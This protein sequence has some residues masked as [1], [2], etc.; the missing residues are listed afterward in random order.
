MAVVEPAPDPLAER[1]RDHLRLSLAGDVG[2]ATLTTGL[3]RLRVRARALPAC[4]LDAVDLS[5]VRWGRRLAVPL[6]VSCMT[7]GVSEAGPVNRALA[8]AAQAHGVAL[9]L[10][11]GRVLLEGDGVRDRDRVASFAVRD[12]APDVLLFANLGAVSLARHGPAACRRL[13]AMCEADALVLH[14]NSVQE[15]I[16]AAA[17]GPAGGDTEFSRVLPRIAEVCAELEVPVLVKEVGFGLAPEDVAALV[18]AGVAG[19]DVA[20]AGGTNWARVEGL[21]DG[22]AGA[23]AA[24]FADWGL[25]TAEAVRGARRVLD[26][27]D[28][29]DVTLI[30]SG[31]LRHGV[32]ALK[33][34]C[35]G[36]DLAGVARGLLAAG[37]EGPAAAVAAVGVI[38][39]QLRIAAW[40]AG[41]TEL[42][43][44]T[45]EWLTS[46]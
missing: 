23:V 5:Q 21:R 16:Q 43:D 24:A 2:F 17:G 35:L 29:G 7:G 1:K 26:E 30:G 46:D 32:D 34:L 31:G 41:A 4:D 10:G 40:A 28:R 18:D 33:V 27:R 36:A 37:A 14:L 15:A 22:R 3:E 12:L 38:A 19:V 44:L 20:G 25:P 13:V 39:E 11:S 8:V 45:E 42:A 6:L 9:G